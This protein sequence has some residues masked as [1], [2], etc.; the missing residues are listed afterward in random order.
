MFETG[1]WYEFN[2][3]V[4]LVIEL[5]KYG[6]F[7]KFTC[8]TY[9]FKIVFQVDF[10]CDSNHVILREFFHN[11]WYDAHLEAFFILHSIIILI[12]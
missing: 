8:C 9:I 5:I 11:M 6:N 3:D 7:S 12:M 10:N 2:D 1:F 4:H